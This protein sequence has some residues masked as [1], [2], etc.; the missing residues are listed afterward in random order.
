LS[1]SGVTKLRKATN[2][3]PAKEATMGALLVGSS[4]KG[5][6]ELR[7][8]AAGT[9]ALVSTKDKKV[10]PALAKLLEALKDQG[11]IQG[12]T[13]VVIGVFGKNKQHVFSLEL[14]DLSE[15]QEILQWTIGRE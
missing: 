15:I 12:P 10:S 11:E 5:F 2:P 7:A 3:L 8:A 6:S 4:T 1:D 14:E 13:E 9:S